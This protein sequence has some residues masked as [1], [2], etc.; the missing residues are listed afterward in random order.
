MTNKRTGNRKGNGKDNRR[1]LRDDKQKG[2]NKKDKTKRTKQKDK[3][4]QGQYALAHT[5]QCG[6]AGLVGDAG[7][8]LVESGEEDLEDWGGVVLLVADA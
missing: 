5:R 6:L 7:D 8:K 3:R 4:R 1:S 2:Q